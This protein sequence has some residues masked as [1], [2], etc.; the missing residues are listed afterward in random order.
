M[1]VDPPRLEIRRLSNHALRAWIPLAPHA[2][3]AML[4]LEMR[5]RALAETAPGLAV[6]RPMGALIGALALLGLAHFYLQPGGWAHAGNALLCLL[7][8]TLVIAIEGGWRAARALGVQE[9][10]L[11]VGKGQLLIWHEGEKEP[12]V[13]APLARCK[14]ELTGGMLVV[15]DPEDLHAW[16]VGCPIVEIRELLEQI[17]AIHQ[18]FG[19]AEDIPTELRATLERS[20]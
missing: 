13:D 1:N 5:R 11:A 17:D 3:V 8:L 16:E 6:T 18:A 14:L 10:A 2:L 19:S 12:E 20:R 4:P 15:R 9:L 7:A